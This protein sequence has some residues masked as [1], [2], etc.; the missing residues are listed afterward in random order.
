MP[1]GRI[2]AGKAGPALWG[3]H[4]LQGLPAPVLP[5]GEQLLQQPPPQGQALVAPPAVSQGLVQRVQVLLRTADTGAAGFQGIRGQA[6][7]Q[8]PLQV[9]GA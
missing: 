7:A 2:P 5:A 6:P 1:Q 4:L 3:P 9:T 8:T